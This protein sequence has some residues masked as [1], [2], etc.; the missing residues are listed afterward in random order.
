MRK[1]K[2]ICTLGPAT[3]GDGILRKMLEGG[4]NVARLN[5]SH[6]NH[7]EHLKRV[8][9]FKRLRD[10]LDLPAALLLDTKGPEIRLKR[11]KG[12]AAELA[13]GSEF[14]LTPEDI[15]G[16]AE[17]A[18]VTYFNLAED[19]KKGDRILLDDGL[20][21][22][23]VSEIE[24]RDVRCR[25]INGGV[26]SDNK[27]VNVPNVRLN[28][29]FVSERDIEDLRFAALNEFDF[30]AASFVRDAAC[31]KE[32]RGVVDGFG[33]GN[34]KI[35]AKIEN[36]EGVD[37]IE[38]ILEAADG[39]MVAR[40][41]MG[42]EIPFEELPPIQKKIIRMCNLAG[43][44]VITATQMLESMIKNPRPTRAEITDV[45]NAVYDGTDAVMLS[46][47]TSIGRYPVEAVKT[48]AKIALYTEGDIDYARRFEAVH[49]SSSENITD[50]VSHAACEAAHSLDAA[51]IISVT[52]SGH[53][54]QKV[55]KYRPA[56]PIAAAAISRDVYRQ[57]SLLWGVIPLL[58]EYG[59]T[60]DRIFAGA[61]KTA[62]GA[63]VINEGDLVVITGGMPVGVSGTTNTLKVQVVEDK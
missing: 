50:A 40:G 1:T 7:E 46:G 29:P 31:V 33:G 14:V 9:E 27:G 30:I 52:K 37:N 61:I 6:G 51:A 54:A 35:I 36:R 32:M 60:T 13:G 44:P 49:P 4:M 34:I 25:V 10:E 19:V 21:E 56:S 2:I 17:S 63:G 24:G 38:S 5:F 20:V 26:I 58:T 12:G 23:L 18:S 3:D 39:I 41:D 45:A 15:E 11:F 59:D 62:R 28:M 16:N 48:M 22:L 43:K 8:E 55:S 53:T 57:M 47:E 42:V